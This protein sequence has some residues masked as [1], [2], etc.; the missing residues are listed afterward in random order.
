MDSEIPIEFF[1]LIKD[2]C[3]N[4]LISVNSTGNE[5]IKDF[6]KQE[7]KLGVNYLQ[8]WEMIHKA[9]ITFELDNLSKLAENLIIK[10]NKEV[11]GKECYVLKGLFQSVE[12]RN[13][14]LTYLESMLYQIPEEFGDVEYE[15]YVDKETYE[16]YGITFD[17]TDLIKTLSGVED[18]M[19]NKLEFE[20]TYNTGSAV[21]FPKAKESSID[22]YSKVLGAMEDISTGAK[23]LNK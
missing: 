15:I 23:K 2:F 14:L 1:A 7:I 3:V 22:S 20:V 21:K 9:Y 10:G 6:I 12:I 13:V 11:N 16:I 4:K 8:N 17:C 5:K 19:E 18:I